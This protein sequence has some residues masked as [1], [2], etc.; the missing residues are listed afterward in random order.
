MKEIKHLIRKAYVD[1]LAGL[2][3]L[4]Q[5]IPI[6]D[7]KLTVPPAVLNLGNSTKIQA[8]VIIQ[9]QTVND[10]PISKCGINQETSIQLDIVT[11]YNNNSGQ[12]L[13]AELIAQLVFDKLFDTDSKFLELTIPGVHVWRGWLEG[14][15][16]IEDNTL[17]KSIYRNILIFNHSVSQ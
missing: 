12:S 9:N 1:K 3:Y 10:S 14:S 8:F 13:H 17:D 4:S 7:N 6:G 16:I 2:S 5:P 11:V 15:R